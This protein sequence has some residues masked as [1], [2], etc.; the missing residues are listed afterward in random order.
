MSSACFTLSTY[1]LFAASVVCTGVPTFS[2]LF[3]PA[4]TVCEPAIVKPPSKSADC[5]KVA[6]PVTVTVSPAA[7]PSVTLP[8]ACKAPS[9]S[10]FPV[11]VVFPV[12]SNVPA[13]RVLPVPLATVNLSV[14]ILKLPADAMAPFEVSE[15]TVAEPDTSNVPF[16]ST[17]LPNSIYSLPFVVIN[18]I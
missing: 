1:P 3:P 15:L 2:I 7:L 17:F 16:K 10:K 6:V 18:L 11:K 12:T 8:S 9:T 5:V 4:S 13:T 14:F